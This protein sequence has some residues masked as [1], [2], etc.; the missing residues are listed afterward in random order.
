M[1]QPG[2][3]KDPQRRAFVKK[4]SA[5]LVGGLAAAGPAAAGLTVF[6]DPLTRKGQASDFI[7]VASID[8]LPADG[9]PRKF[10]VVADRF[11][12][13]N[14]S[15]HVPIGVVY[16]RR[17]GENKVEAMNVVCPHLGCFVDYLPREKAFACPC[18]NSKF[19]LDGTIADP[20]SPSPRPLD[21]LGVEVR[22]ETEVWVR[23]QNFLAGKSEK[24]PVS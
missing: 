9:I 22:N 17:T 14:K 12:A 7:R 3:A 21:A 1:D 13:W 8:S 5:V 20:K 23:F 2:D 6:L 24:I 4:A 15:P 16:L 19:A 10:S 11:D 18:H